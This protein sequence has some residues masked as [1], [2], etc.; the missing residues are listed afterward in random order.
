MSY[1]LYFLVVVGL[2]GVDQLSKLY[3]VGNIELNTHIKIIDNFFYLTNVRNTGAGFSILEGEMTLFYIVTPLALALFIFLL[4]KAKKDAKLE[5]MALILMISGT[6]GNYIDRLN[7]KYVIDFLDFKIFGYDFPVF[8][9]ADSF[10]TIGV[11]IFL[12]TV[13]LENKYAKN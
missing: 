5:K 11:L 3:I 6:I 12:I 8:N 4:Y 1:L 13:L 10:L 2:V 9:V 7:L